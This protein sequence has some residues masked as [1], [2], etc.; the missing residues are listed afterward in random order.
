MIFC[1][2]TFFVFDALEGVKKRRAAHLLYIPTYIYLMG[3]LIF[4]LQ[5]LQDPI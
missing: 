5:D 1:H 4:A 3:I 2:F